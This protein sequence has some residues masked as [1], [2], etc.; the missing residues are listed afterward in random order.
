MFATEPFDV[1]K[2]RSGG[3]LVMKWHLS[4]DAGHLQKTNGL[5]NHNP[6][7]GCA[8]TRSFT[9]YLKLNSLRF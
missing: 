1:F 5:L 3:V 6:V 9:V 8:C 4:A 2:L 7:M